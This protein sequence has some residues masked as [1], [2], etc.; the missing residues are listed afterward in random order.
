MNCLMCNS[1]IQVI[2]SFYE[3]FFKKKIFDKWICDFCYSKFKV[4]EKDC[5]K[6][7]CKSDSKI[8]G[9]C[10]YW[11]KEFGKFVKHT[12]WYTYNREMHDFFRA[13]KRNGDV[14]LANIFKRMI[15]ESEFFERFDIITYIPTTSNHFEKR[16]FN[17]VKEL[18][19]GLPLK[20]LFEITADTGAQASKTREER[21][22]SP[23]KFK[24]V[25]ELDSNQKILI[26]DDIYTTGR[27]LNHARQCVLNSNPGSVVE[28]FSLA[29]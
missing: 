10:L 13:Y 4:I 18:Y 21:L 24:L 25:E 26:V 27:T 22:R 28:T 11:K 6:Y 5:C 19:S 15:S 7:C 8:C 2:P 20:K 9:D 12:A 14:Q 3:L 29:R 1:Y 16:Q 17:P 23:Q